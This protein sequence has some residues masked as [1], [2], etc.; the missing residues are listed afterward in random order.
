MYALR[1]ENCLP[2][3]HQDVR[4]IIVFKSILFYF[5]LRIVGLAWAVEYTTKSS[6]FT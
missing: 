2:Q 3:I 1:V 5:L 6:I 4:L